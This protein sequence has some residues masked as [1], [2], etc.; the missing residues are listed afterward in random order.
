MPMGL[1]IGVG[2]S[3]G[4]NAPG[5][6]LQAETETWLDRVAS[7]GGG[8]IPAGQISALDALISSLKADGI[9]STFKMFNPML[10]ADGDLVAV[11]TPLLTGTGGSVLWTNTNFVTGD[12]TAVGGLLSAT[13]TKHLDTGYTPSNDSLT[14]SNCFIGLF[15]VGDQ[16]SAASNSAN[17]TDRK[18]S[19]TSRFQLNDNAK[20]NG[21]G[22]K[23]PFGRGLSWLSTD[24]GLHAFGH[25]WGRTIR[26]N[27]S[28]I[29]LDAPV[30]LYAGWSGAALLPGAGQFGTVI[31]GTALTVAQIRTLRN[32][33][34]TFMQALGRTA[35]TPLCAV[36]GDSITRGTGATELTMATSRFSRIYCNAITHREANFGRPSGAASAD[37]TISGGT[38]RIAPK[39][40]ADVAEVLA[41]SPAKVV[42]LLGTN[43]CGLVDTDVNGTPALITAYQNSMSAII[44]A[45]LDGGMSASN[46]IVGSRTYANPAAAQHSLA[47][48]ALYVAAA[49]AAASGKNV[50]Y[51]DVNV[52]MKDNGGN[53]LVIADNVHPNDSGHAAIAAAFALASTVYVPIISVA[54]VVTGTPYV[55]QT[56]TCSTG[57]WRNS[58]TSFAYQWQRNGVDIG[59]A[60]SN[61]YVMTIADEGIPIRCVVTASN[62]VGAGTPANSNAVEAWVPTDLGSDLKAWY[63]A[64]D[65]TTITIDTGVSQWNDRSGNGRHLVQATVANQPAYS[66]TGFDGTRPG[67][68]YDG[69]NDR[70]V[71]NPGGSLFRNVTGTTMAVMMRVAATTP[72]QRAM[73]VSS[74]SGNLRRGITIDTTLKSSGRR[75]DG[76]TNQDINH[77]VTPAVDTPFSVVARVDHSTAMARQCHNGTDSSGATFQ[78]TGSTSDTDAVDLATGALSSGGS[79]LN[80]RTAEELYINANVSDAVRDK[81]SGYLHH[82]WGALAS[83]S[84]GHAY[85]TAYPTP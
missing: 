78:T 3:L 2:P 71:R 20:I 51:M 33:L 6:S 80:G 24:S 1:G 67:I 5:V 31:I 62:A 50:Q 35:T 13:T 47:K 37:V 56:L 57:S 46:I 58:P 77:G 7:N 59:G 25:D 34:V 32:R 12:Y 66:G 10:G 79:P 8:A 45:L 48:Q 14:S 70:L 72:L 81:I 41:C 17:I 49:H 21:R 36:V 16:N 27:T 60:T 28:T 43:D 29:S 23:I 64:L 74:G 40:D 19:V 73:N 69:V 65:A 4:G 55:G 63:D 53:S 54:P 61:T 82:R 76:D 84:G 22:D 75:L 26:E 11:R 68:T 38:S 42:V 15:R 9:F 30:S 83:L 52:Y 39:R 44:Q 18:A 85:K